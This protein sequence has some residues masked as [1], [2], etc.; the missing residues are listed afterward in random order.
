M[1]LVHAVDD[2]EV[3]LAVFRAVVGRIEG[4]TVETFAV[5][6]Q[7]L[8]RAIALLPDLILLD[9]MMPDID[10]LEF[11]R[12]LS[13][14]P[15]GGAVPVVMVTADRESDVR[16]RALAMGAR[17]FLT[18]P[19]DKAELTVRVRNLLALHAAEIQLR[20][21]ATWLAAEVKK[22][23]AGILARER[24]AILR[25]AR[26]AEYRDPETGAHLVR[27][28]RYTRLI[29]ERLGLPAAEQDLLLEAAP[30]HDIGKIGIPDAVLLKPGRLTDDEFA[31]MKQ[32]TA[33][34]RD[35]LHDSPAPLLQCA[36]AI[37]LAH[38]EKFDGSGYPQGLAGTAIPLYGRIVAVADVFDALT[39][40]R[41][42]KMA[43]PLA[44]AREFLRAEAGRH[45]DP[46]CVAAFLSAWDEVR[47]IH[48][49]DRDTSRS[50]P[51]PTGIR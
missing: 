8:E 9:Y 31:V 28:S 20:D 29:A 37:A 17:D 38:H 12:R 10:G 21:R 43:W 50:E 36:A 27:M 41:P 45:F 18:K 49:R 25:L 42:Y 47:A 33:I 44:R 40:E 16:Y 14:L 35:I 32:H 4:V 2:N 23:T 1:P 39:S 22:A 15:G 46:D 7:A 3:N 11:M 5:P 26:A 34:G 51:P 13:A 30:M 48:D 19:I 6:A 24:E